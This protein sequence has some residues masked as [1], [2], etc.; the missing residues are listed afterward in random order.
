MY[1]HSNLLIF[2]VPEQKIKSSSKFFTVD[3][4]PSFNQFENKICNQNY[5][6]TNKSLISLITHSLLPNPLTQKNR[7]PRVSQ[8]SEYRQPKPT[9]TFVA[10]QNDRRGVRHPGRIGPAS[11]VYIYP[12]QRASRPALEIGRGQRGAGLASGRSRRTRW[13]ARGAR[14][15]RINSTP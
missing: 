2:A 12:L 13:A 14:P 4:T 9:S 1:K 6:L 11:R 15:P 5:L 8:T 3:L 7:L 10:V